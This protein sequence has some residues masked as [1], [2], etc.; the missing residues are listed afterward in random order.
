MHREVESSFLFTRLLMLRLR[1]RRIEIVAACHQA[2]GI[3][4]LFAEMIPDEQ[5][6]HEDGDKEGRVEVMQGPNPLS[7]YVVGIDASG[8]TGP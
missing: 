4:G 5:T 2:L 8:Y 1:I 7:Q 3:S 6:N